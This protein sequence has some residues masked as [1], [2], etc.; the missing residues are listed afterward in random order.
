MS[1]REFKI[2]NLITLK[3]E[4]NI[5]NIY[6]NKEL[7]RQCMFLL[8][9]KLSLDEID[10]YINDVK[11]VD[12]AITNLDH[13]LE[14]EI[15]EEDIPADTEFWAHCSN[16]QVW[17]ENEYDTRLLHRN[18][19]FPLLQR[20]TECGDSFAKIKFKEEIVKRF[21]SGSFTVVKYLLEN[22]YDRYLTK[23]EFQYAILDY[24]E[25]EVLK[26]I[27][28][29]THIKHNLAESL[30]ISGG[31]RWDDRCDHYVAKDKKITELQ[32]F[33]NEREI[34]DF[35][36]S[37]AELKGLKKLYISIGE[38]IESLPV[39]KKKIN[40][41]EKLKIAC[42]G[43]PMIPDLFDK[44]PNLKELLIGYGNFEK[45]PSTLGDLPYLKRLI[46]NNCLLKSLPESIVNLKSLEVLIL[47]GT[48]T[49]LPF[50]ITRLNKIK[51]LEINSEDVEER[52]ESWIKDLGIQ[53]TSTFEFS[54]GQKYITF[55]K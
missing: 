52:I 7:F 16:I 4:N 46:I 38:S 42:A 19:A 1:V 36:D 35:P 25:V 30:E 15:F 32:L 8:L 33:F 3:L 54:R 18:L 17:V 6:V 53:E 20:L 26:K 13:S 40:L 14:K 49:D 12:D 27:E 24:E 2:N 55:T 37:I 34:K 51:K 39:P 45:I 43:F 9:T 44:F 48:I 11:S 23:E 10:N 28:D 31:D 47:R 21:E 22:E 50:S 29:I 41:V 5:T